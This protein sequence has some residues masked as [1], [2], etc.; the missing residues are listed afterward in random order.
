MYGNLYLDPLD[1]MLKRSERV[2]IFERY[3][4]DSVI[5]SPDK[6]ELHRLHRRADEFIGDVLKLRLN[7]KTVIRPVSQGID[8]VGYRIWPGHVSLR[9]STALRMKRYLRLVER[10]YRDEEISFEK[11]HQTVISYKALMKH[12]DCEALD[13]HIFDRFVLTHNKEVDG[14]DGRQSA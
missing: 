2:E 3:M 10:Q 12:V 6:D 5:V 13:K 9:K 8:F 4:D 7:E 1:Q 11:A 14:C